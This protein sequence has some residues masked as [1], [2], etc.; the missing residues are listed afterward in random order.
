MVSGQQYLIVYMWD[1]NEPNALVIEGV[2][3]ETKRYTV[4][5]FQDDGHVS[6]VAAEVDSI[7]RMKLT[8]RMTRN[9][10]GGIS[11]RARLYSK[12]GI[13]AEVTLRL[14][15]PRPISTS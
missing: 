7:T 15:W 3:P 10:F 4:W 11:E 8:F 5:I 12:S 2:D 9:Q 6:K 13:G 14:S 1:K